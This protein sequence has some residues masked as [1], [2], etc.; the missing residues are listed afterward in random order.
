ML[1]ISEHADTCNI[2]SAHLICTRR[3]WA[4]SLCKRVCSEQLLQ[5]HFFTSNAAKYKSTFQGVM[6]VAA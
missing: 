1:L 4:G 5:C 6:V 2:K 3:S